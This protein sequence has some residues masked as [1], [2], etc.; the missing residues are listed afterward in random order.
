[1]SGTEFR[2]VLTV[3][4]RW[5]HS[6]RLRL[7]LH[8]VQTDLVVTTDRTCTTAEIRGLHTVNYKS[9][10]VNMSVIVSRRVGADGA[11]ED[12]DSS[13]PSTLQRNKSV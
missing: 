5:R 4:F 7:E 3:F 12:D 13:K 1:M 6:I 10:L 8:K 9:D 2:S 11:E